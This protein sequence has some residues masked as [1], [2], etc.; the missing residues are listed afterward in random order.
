MG[1]REGRK[2]HS[3]RTAAA[4]GA[5]RQIAVNPN[6]HIHRFSSSWVPL[7][8]LSFGNFFEAPCVQ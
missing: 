2:S 6:F 5:L 3:L 1:R 7:R 4:E 8:Q